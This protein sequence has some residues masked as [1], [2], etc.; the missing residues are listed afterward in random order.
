MSYSDI[1]LERL[2]DHVQETWDNGNR[3]DAISILRK[4]KPSHQ[5][6]AVAIL[7]CDRLGDHDKGH[8]VRRVSKG[9]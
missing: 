5:M 7:V 2:A 9:S 6:A 1:E 8:F 3:S 4:I